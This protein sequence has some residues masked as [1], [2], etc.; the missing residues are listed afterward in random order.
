MNRKRP[1]ALSTRFTS[2]STW[3]TSCTLHSVRQH[4]TVS[5]LASA[6]G[7]FS[8]APGTDLIGTG[9]PARCAAARRFMPSDG[10][11]TVRL[12]TLAGS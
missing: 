11:T 4:T 8:P 9:E 6:N 12:V 3:P 10:S 2:A 1:P 5:K 7:S